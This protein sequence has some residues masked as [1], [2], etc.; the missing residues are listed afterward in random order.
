MWY[1]KQEL[2]YVCVRVSSDW[3]CK[4]SYSKVQ[5][6]KTTESKVS[7]K[8]GEIA[9]NLW[10]HQVASTSRYENSKISKKMILHRKWSLHR[11]IALTVRLTRDLQ[12]SCGN[13]IRGLVFIS[14]QDSGR[15]ELSVLSP[16]ITYRLKHKSS[17]GAGQGRAWDQQNI[18]EEQVG[19]ETSSPFMD[20][21]LR[22]ICSGG[23]RHVGDCAVS[24]LGSYHRVLVQD[25]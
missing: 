11:K 4:G 5:L 24:L 13:S 22:S 19:L 23:T 21:S 17:G 16:H 18:H 6:F 7:H 12:M 25:P 3:I 20:R 8:V 15:E 14:H 9:F 1:R 2:G 10:G